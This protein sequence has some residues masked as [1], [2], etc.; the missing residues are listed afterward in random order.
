MTAL[1]VFLPWRI[2]DPRR[3]S[4]GNRYDR[5]VVD[6]LRA[7]GWNC[8]EHVVPGEWPQPTRAACGQLERALAALEPGALVLLD[9]VMAPPAADA[10]VNAARRL[11][12]VLLLHMPFGE[13]C[14]ELAAAERSVI[15]ACSAVIATST[16]TRQWTSAHYALPLRR[17]QVATPGVDPAPLA[18]RR[19]PGRYLL[20][21]ANVSHEKG[22]DVL[23]GAL[24]ALADL[25]WRCTCAGAVADD[26]AFMD[27]LRITA[28]A[29]G[30]DRRLRFAGALSGAALEAAYAGADVLVVASR[31]ESYGM[32]VTEALARGLP[33]I[34]ADTGGIVEAVGQ[35]PDG[36]TPGI[37][38]DPDSPAALAAALR[39]WLTQPTLRKA[40]RQ[41][42]AAR[43]GR[44][45]GWNVTADA[46]AR[47]FSEVAHGAHGLA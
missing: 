29:A 47:V 39:A 4:G 34:A 1:H 24:A 15:E 41:A 7:R 10:L 12:I 46:I 6:G 11:R 18:P 2:D 22:H 43:R 3:P 25:A 5:H 37:L 35:A 17:V 8:R 33:V 36:T 40:L 38:V 14:P 31:R 42:A 21:V 30:I 44:L 19:E 28:R 20:C 27:G 13:A 45:S 23:V 26:A 32:V 16:W 9:G